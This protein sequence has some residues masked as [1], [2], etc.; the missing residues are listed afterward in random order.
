MKNIWKA[1]IAIGVFILIALAKLG[2]DVGKGAVKSGDDL[3]TDVKEN[4]GKILGYVNQ[5]KTFWPIFDGIKA[6]GMIVLEMIKDEEVEIYTRE[7]DYK[8]EL[9]EIRGKGL[10]KTYHNGKLVERKKHGDEKYGVDEGHSVFR[11]LV[12]SNGAVKVVDDSIGP[13]IN[14]HYE[15]EA[16]I[17]GGITDIDNFIIKVSSEQY[18]QS[19]ESMRTQMTRE[20]ESTTNVKRVQVKMEAII[21]SEY[22]CHVNPEQMLCNSKDE[23]LVAVIYLWR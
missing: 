6:D 22:S 15:M 12:M 2:D 1:A 8:F 5:P 11:K 17:P 23:E 10:T 13:N 9:V 7:S 20:F 3:A 21:G 18:S 16:D 14:F 4:P 19:L